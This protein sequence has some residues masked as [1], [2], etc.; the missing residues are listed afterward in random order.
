M[1]EYPLLPTPKPERGERP[2]GGG[3]GGGMVTPSRNRQSQRIGPTFQRLKDAF[4]SDRDPVSLRDDPVGIAPERAIVFEVAGSIGDFSAAVDKI[5]GLD[6][7]LDE[8]LLLE[9]DEDF[10]VAET[11]KGK[12]PGIRDDKLIAGRLYMAMPDVQAL[13][14]LL[15]LWRR[16]QDG[17][18]APRGFKP[19]FDVFDHL[20]DLRAWG[21]RD[22]VPDETIAYLEEE[23]AAADTDALVRVEVELWYTGTAAKRAA[24]KASFLRAVETAGGTIIDQSEIEAIGYIGFLLDLPAAEVRRLID[25]DEV[26]IAVCDDV[27]MVRPQSTIEF[28]VEV[29]P[30]DDALP[31]SAEPVEPVSPIAAIFDAMPVQN[32]DLLNGRLLLDDPDD[33]DAMSVVAERRHGTE[34]A[35]LVLHGDRNR[36]EEPLSRP[37]YFRPVMYAPGSNQDE[38]PVRDRLLLDV[39]YRAVLRMKAGDN[40]G[41]PTAPDVFIVNL[42]LG[43]RNRPFSGPMSPW[44]RLLDY[45]ADR[46]G[47]LFLVSA[48]NVKTPLSVPEFSGLIDFEAATPEEREAAIMRALAD[49]QATRTLLSPAEALNVITVGAWHEDDAPAV[50][51]SNTFAPFA[52]APGPNISSA[53]GLGHRKVVKP[54]IFMP[55]GRE[56]VRVVGSGS[57]V[58]LGMVNPGRLY[59]LRCAVPAAGG[60]T[61]KEGLSAGTSAATAL[62][63]RAAHQIFDAL[64]DPDN[65]NLLDDVDPAFYAVIVK[66][67]LVHRAKW[68]PLGELFEQTWSPQGGG[69]AYAVRRDLIARLLGY[70]RPATDEAMVCASNR[71]TM[72]GFGEIPA[73]ENAALYRIPLPPSLASVK[74]PRALTIS[75]A[76]FSPVNIRHQAYRRAKLEVKPE[77]EHDRFGVKRVAGQPSDKAIPRG[78]LF[79]VRFEGER[80]VAFVDGNTL[81]LR[82]FCREQG[83]ALD[84]SIRYGLAVTV[85]AGQA[86]PVYNE[87]R[88]ALGI[89]PRP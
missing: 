67:L 17:E 3:G 22:R 31:V 71:A 32:H 54:D 33:Y 86:V 61:G 77:K 59:G 53:L 72:I 46:F 69:G 76:W 36:G 49:Q 79:H 38:Q 58:S 52:S 73:D 25:R 28:P 68:G 15:S 50:N 21:P 14:H 39:I 70:G 19:W 27:M 2:R 80:A 20:H 9:P 47:L 23:L 57:A 26:N 4:E 6:F 82:V 55:G 51:G 85:E 75:L 81:A 45:L 18:S 10:G 7:L 16:Y 78:S 24:G 43:D 62:T 83:G 44:G 35:S 34:M 63:T 87:I 37:V 48:G 89:R 74:E 88:Q 8:E 29:E 60:D 30:L 12:E 84:Q 42:S 56:L 66:A 11:R 5:G 65:G 1:T 64:S 41:D 40:E 13:R